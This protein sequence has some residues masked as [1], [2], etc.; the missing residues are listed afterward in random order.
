MQE[1]YPALL[2]ADVVVLA[3]PLYYWTI[4]GQLKNTIDRMYALEEGEENHLRGHDRSGVLL[5]AAAGN[6]FESSVNYYENLMEH[7]QWKDLGKVLADG[8]WEKGDIEGKEALTKAYEL[9]KSI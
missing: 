1:I 2:E 5:M 4:S 7:L 3:S 6:A 9:G 8:V